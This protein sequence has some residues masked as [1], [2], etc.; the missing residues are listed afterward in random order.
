MTSFLRIFANQSHKSYKKRGLATMK[1]SI[2][3]GNA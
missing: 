3:Y 1:I 2:R